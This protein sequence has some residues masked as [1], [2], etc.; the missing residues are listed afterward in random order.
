MTIWRKAGRALCSN[1]VLAIALL[2]IGLFAVDRLSTR[3]HWVEVTGAGTGNK[4]FVNLSTAGMINR[5][6]ANGREVTH[7]W[8]GPQSYDVKELPE[9]LLKLKPVTLAR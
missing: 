6:T 3:E 1:A 4:N 2:V 9:E 8:N 7:I 5:G